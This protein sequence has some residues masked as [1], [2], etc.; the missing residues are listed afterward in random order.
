[1]KRTVSLGMVLLIVVLTAATTFN[2]TYMSVWHSFNRRLDGLS[3]RE[4]TFAKLAEMQNYID[5]YYITDYDSKTLAEGA[6][7]GMAEALPDQWSYYM[8]AETFAA[9]N[10]PS[11]DDYVGIGAQGMYDEETEAIRINEVYADGPADRAGL[12]YFDMIIAID[13]ISVAERGYEE[14]VAAI[15]GEAGTTVTVTYVAVADGEVRTIEITR[16]E[17]TEFNLQYELLDSGIGYI[18]IKSFHDSVDR[19]FLDAVDHLLEA[20]AKGLIFDVRLN[21]GGKLTVLRNMLDPLLPEGK[22]VEQRDKDGHVNALYSDA[23]ALDLPMA[24]LTHAYS[25]SAAEF[26]AAALQEYGKAIIVGE[27]TTGKGYAQNMY[28]LS[29]G[30]ALVLSTYQYVTPNGVDLSK[31]GVTPDVEVSLTDEELYSLFYTTRD[32]DRQLNA[33]VDALLASGSQE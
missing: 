14:S 21:G 17:V 22:I 31:C 11:L 1:M 19:Q 12:R 6:A 15:R 28:P 2:I 33:A 23:Q 4:Q 20:G 10:D 26:F 7:V 9:Y 24:V 25:Y 32:Q 3:E 13:G 27:K 18:R 8:D 5:T 30:S 16:A 29:D